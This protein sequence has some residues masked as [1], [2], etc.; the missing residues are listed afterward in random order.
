MAAQPQNEQ[1]LVSISVPPEDFAALEHLWLRRRYASVNAV[2]A[3]G[4]SSVLHG[5]DEGLALETAPQKKPE[6][7]A[8]PSIRAADSEGISKA[9]TVSYDSGSF[10]GTDRRTTS[11]SR[12]VSNVIDSSVVLALN[13]GMRTMPRSLPAA[14]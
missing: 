9:Q 13:F 10:G 1:H 7:I 14:Y 8:D 4:D 6:E 5:E 11:R 12:S 3:C 2:C